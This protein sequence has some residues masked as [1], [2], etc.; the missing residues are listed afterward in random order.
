MLILFIAIQNLGST[1]WDCSGK[2]KVKVQVKDVVCKQC[3]AKLKLRNENNEIVD[4]VLGPWTLG[5]LKVK[6]KKS[7]AIDYSPDILICLREA[8]DF[9]IQGKRLFKC[10]PVLTSFLQT[11]ALGHSDR[12]EAGA[13]L[14]FLWCTIAQLT[15]LPR[16]MYFK[17]SL[18]W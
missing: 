8:M 7:K 16:D 4:N 3:I 2:G 14:P 11:S 5:T 9:L 13:L 10:L 15:F 17:F 1:H 18:S 6:M 12:H